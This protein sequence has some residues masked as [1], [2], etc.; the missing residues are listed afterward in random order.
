MPFSS[1]RS[2]GILGIVLFSL[3]ESNLVFL[4]HLAPFFFFFFFFYGRRFLFLLGSSPE[5]LL[6]VIFLHAFSLP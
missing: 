6:H 4:F 5:L 3:L 2:I 1:V